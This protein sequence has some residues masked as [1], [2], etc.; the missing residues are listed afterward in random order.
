MPNENK[1]RGRRGEAAKRKRDDADDLE[2]APESSK[3]SRASTLG[4]YDQNGG[5]VPLGTEEEHGDEFYEDGTSYEHPERPFYG[6]LDDEEQEYF[7]KAD[8][9]LEVNQFRDAEE[10]ALFIEN[11]HKE[12]A[13]KELK[14]ACS[15]SCSRLLER[16]IL[17]STP[18]QLKAIFQKLQG[19][20]AALLIV[21][22]G[23]R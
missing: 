19:Q 20:Y 18:Q 5:F 12:A 9:M 2:N 7:K 11:V 10:R 23:L 13:G 6:L 3:R 22:D 1:K 8:D 14:L 15:Q 4:D 21:L 17:L 16:L